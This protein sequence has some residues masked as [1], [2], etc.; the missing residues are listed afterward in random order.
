MAQEPNDYREKLYLN[1]LQS[2]GLSLD[3]S[4]PSYELQE[5]AVHT[6]AAEY[7]KNRKYADIVMQELRGFEEQ[8]V[9]LE[10][11]CMIQ[12]NEINNLLKAREDDA[13]IREDMLAEIQRLEDDKEQHQKEINELEKELLG[14]NCLQSHA[15]ESIVNRIS[16]MK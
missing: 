10:N 11:D 6:I 8:M 2:I 9:A 1:T 15:R 13:K 12:Q 14:N 4:D 7:I 5:K 3:Q 16:N